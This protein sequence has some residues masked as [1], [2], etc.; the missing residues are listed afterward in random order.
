MKSSQFYIVVSLSALCL[1]LSV[2]VITLGQASQSA[3]MRFQKRQNE[4]QIELQQRQA[5]V[6]KGSTSNQV[7][8]AILQDIAAASLKNPK[9]KEVLAKNGYNV[10]A[11]PSPS[12]ASATSPK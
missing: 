10:T 2:V 8:T 5:E 6:N 12:D 7:G 4:I 3:Q 1:I 11:S 9:M